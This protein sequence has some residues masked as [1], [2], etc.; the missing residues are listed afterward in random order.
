MVFNIKCVRTNMDVGIEK[1]GFYA[2]SCFLD[3]GELAVARKDNLAYVHDQ[4][5]CYERPVYP[6][7]EDPVTMAVNAAKQIVTQKDIPN[8]D[9]LIVGTESGVDFGKPISSWVHR[10][11]NLSNYCRNFEL[12]HACYSVTA[13]LKMALSWI[14]SSD[15]PQKKVLV[16]GTDLSRCHLDT[17]IEYIAGGC[18]VALL[19]SANPKILAIDIEKSGYWSGEVS[20]TYRPTSRHEI[21]NSELSMCSYLDVLEMAYSHF[22]SRTSITDYS[23]FKKHIYHLP[24]PGMAVH[25]HKAMLENSN[26]EQFQ[27]DFASKVSGSLNLSK[28][29]GS[30]YGCS[31]WISLISLL[32]HSDDLEAGDQ[33]SF[34]SYGS[35]CQGEFYVARLGNQIIEYKKE[36][37]GILEQLDSRIK[38]DVDTYRQIENER[39]N[40]LDN[41]DY[42]TMPNCLKEEIYEHYKKNQYLVLDKVQNYQRFYKWSHL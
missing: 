42:V 15:D 10:Y 36:S 12:K 18:S 38:V 26:K 40:F 22:V 13:A 37:L 16:V 41:K 39:L 35:G 31:N 25:A 23:Q 29:I 11:C 3:L 2:G 30:A 19:I 20:D 28:R 21:A 6:I 8:I 1:I 17:P 34:Y 33:V 7:H 32:L 5:M 24:F 14:K 9:M 4:L 27:K